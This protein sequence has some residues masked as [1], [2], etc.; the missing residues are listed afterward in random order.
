MD[1]TEQW[2]RDW[3]TKGKYTS[4][5]PEAYTIGTILWLTPLGTP[6]VTVT[7][8]HCYIYIIPIKYDKVKHAVNTSLTK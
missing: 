7:I 4:R 1:A 2:R 5:Y 6:I 3:L 8:P